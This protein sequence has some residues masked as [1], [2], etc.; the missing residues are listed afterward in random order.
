VLPALLFV[1]SLF[2]GKNLRRAA[3][4]VGRGALHVHGALAR[5]WAR[6]AGAPPPPEPTRLRIAPF[7]RVRAVT[8]D[9]AQR[10]AMRQAE[11]RG[12]DAD[13]WIEEKLEDETRRWEDSERR[14]A[15][16]KRH[17]QRKHW[18]R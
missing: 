8:E 1:L 17:A 9:E 16:Q 18:G 5:G 15:T 3:K 4:A 6:V 2:F 12:E 14:R 13:E 7:D 11:S 10:L